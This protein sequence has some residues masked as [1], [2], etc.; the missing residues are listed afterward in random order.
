MRDGLPDPDWTALQIRLKPAVRMKM[1]RERAQAFVDELRARGVGVASTVEPMR[2]TELLVYVARSTDHAEAL[3]RA[4]ALTFEVTAR[5]RADAHREVGTLLGYPSCCVDSFVERAAQLDGP[6]G[7]VE[8]EDWLA[9]ASALRR[10]RGAPSRRLNPLLWP[11]RLHLISFYP[12]SYDCAAAR[13]WADTLFAALSRRAPGPAAELDRKLAVKVA[14][15]P[16]GSRAIVDGDDWQPL[17]A[18]SPARADPRLV[19]VAFE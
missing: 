9:A 1:P 19:V 15:A 10:T 8:H 12:C 7:A 13:A 6:D 14:V 3:R 5:A 17:D 2:S 4:E 18:G 16:D 11:L